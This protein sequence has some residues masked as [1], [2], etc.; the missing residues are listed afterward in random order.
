MPQ[1]IGA[2]ANCCK[3]RRWPGRE[4]CRAA[5]KQEAQSAIFTSFN[6]LSFR[7]GHPRKPPDRPCMQGTARRK[8]VGC[9]EG[10]AS[11][12]PRHW[13]APTCGP[14]FPP[15]TSFMCSGRIVILR[16]G[17]GFSGWSECRAAIHSVSNKTRAESWSTC[18]PAS[19][20]ASPSA[21]TSRGR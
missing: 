13:N 14:A 12:L 19:P 9:E 18:R 2:E 8:R 11:L 15:K 10:R 5:R 17:K 6:S 20:P 4:R 3:P 16:T 7:P 21:S 1:D